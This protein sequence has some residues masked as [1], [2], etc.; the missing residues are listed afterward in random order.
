MD[1]ELTFR[2][3][4]GARPFGLIVLRKGSATAR[5]DNDVLHDV[6]LGHAMLWI[7]EHNPN[8][9]L[10]VQYQLVDSPAAIGEQY[11]DRR[12]TAAASSPHSGS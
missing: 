10:P 5:I 7:S 12:G 4:S 6:F 8:P 9:S 11:G 2:A 1:C 3:D